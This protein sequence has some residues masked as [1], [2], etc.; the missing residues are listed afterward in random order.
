MKTKSQTVSYPDLKGS[1]QHLPLKDRPGEK[2][3]GDHAESHGALEEENAKAIK[4]S[5][6]ETQIADEL[7]D[8]VDK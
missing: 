2:G 5:D 7:R 4:K 8:L 1:S 6:A 3:D